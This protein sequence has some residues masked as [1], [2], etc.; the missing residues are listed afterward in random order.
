MTV[1]NADVRFQTRKRPSGAFAAATLM[2]AAALIVRILLLIASHLA[3]KKWHVDLQVIGQEAGFVAW[4][5]ASGK[6]FAN[7]FPHY[8]GATAW[9]A[10][11]FPSLW[12][13]G[14]KIFDPRNGE[15]GVYFAQALNCI[16][17]SATCVPIFWLGNRLFGE[18]TGKAA[19]W[20]WAFF[21]LAIL[22]S[23]EW[24]WDQSLSALLLTLLIC[25]TYQL[26][27][28]AEK[29][30]AWSAYGLGWGFA[31]LVNPTLCVALPFLLMWVVLCRRAAG[32]ATLR[33]ALT[34]ILLFLLALAP[35]TAR[36]Y[37]ALD[38]FTFVKSNFG[39]ELWLGN[40]PDVPKDD[41][42]AAQLHPMNNHQQLFQLAFAGELPYMRAKQHAAIAFIRTRPRDF[43][44]LVSRR[45]LDTWTAWYDSRIDKWIRVLHLSGIAVA[46]CGAF[47][48]LS[49]GGLILALKKN[50]VPVLPMA[51]CAVLLPIPY[52]LTHTTLRYRHPIDPLLVLLPVY[53][54]DSAVRKILGGS[55]LVESPPVSERP[56]A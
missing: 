29:S 55:R 48:A 43:A 2:V 11:V 3:Q 54:V 4:A 7:P 46:F 24:A 17:S 14:L 31:A 32:L 28:T 35:W 13:V 25:A 20:C 38:G 37:F 42:Y 16:F 34:A 1:S 22:F 23:L 36:N 26:A 52:Y 12:A 27:E 47:S 9:L 33:P 40:N 49:L 8:E 21:P 50:F 45:V 51:L 44:A 15:R 5:L 10:P 39:L 6:G 30:A 18:R 56:D 41:V 53:L 19:A